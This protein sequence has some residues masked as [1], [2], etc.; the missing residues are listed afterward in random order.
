[1]NSRGSDRGDLPPS[2]SPQVSA[3]GTSAVEDDPSDLLGRLHLAIPDLEML[4]RRYKDT[5]GELGVRDALVRKREAEAAEAVRHKEEHLNRLMK[6]F[7][8]I[9]S[10]NTREFSK[11]RLHIGNLEE[12]MKEL[13]ENL[14]MCEMQ[15]NELTLRSKDL[16]E[17][18]AALVRERMLVATAAAEERDNLVEDFEAS[19]TG[20]QKQ[21]EEEHAH[22]MELTT[23]VNDAASK[24]D[25]AGKEL[26]EVQSKISDLKEQLATE[27]AS[28]VS[29]WQDKSTALTA[30]HNEAIE[31]LKKSH[32]DDLNEQTRAF[33]GL[34]ES[35]NLR[36][37]QENAILLE[38]ISNLKKAWDEDKTRLETMIEELR[39]VTKGMDEEKVR[40][41]KIIDGSGT[42]TDAKSKG[43]AF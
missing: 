35:L 38:E 20:A 42:E 5:H 3:E 8:E 11:L 30:E 15:R 23:Q 37:T 16:S 6:Q 41:Q 7:Q 13:E 18:N 31:A 14:Q 25:A 2:T 33:V 12:H 34:Q 28:T 43:D 17:Q 36:M 1:M 21:L 24:A 4:L 27:R 40:L 22:V 39:G 29:G 32:K 10:K 26:S 19:K 9:E